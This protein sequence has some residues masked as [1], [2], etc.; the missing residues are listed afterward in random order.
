MKIQKEEINVT[1]NELTD[2]QM[3]NMVYPSCIIEIISKDLVERYRRNKMKQAF[4][5]FLDQDDYYERNM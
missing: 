5:D 4:Y 2:K 1:M 3:V